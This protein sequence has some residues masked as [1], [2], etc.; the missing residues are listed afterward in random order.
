MTIEEYKKLSPVEQARIAIKS[1]IETRE[2]SRINKFCICSK[3]AQDNYCGN[4]YCDKNP[5][6]EGPFDQDK[7]FCFISD[8]RYSFLSRIARF[9]LSFLHRP[10]R[11]DSASLKTFSLDRRALASS[12]ISRMMSALFGQES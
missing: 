10:S 2:N 6:F 5:L 1:N 11:V 9:G 4:I 7:G 8:S 12:T 3:F